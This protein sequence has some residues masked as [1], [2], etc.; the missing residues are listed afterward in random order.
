M[1]F[2]FADEILFELFGT[3]HPIK[4]HNSSL[5]RL[6]VENLYHNLFSDLDLEH[7]DTFYSDFI[8]ERFHTSFKNGLTKYLLGQDYRNRQRRQGQLIR[9]F[10]NREWL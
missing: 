8:F 3:F 6:S 10:Q 9:V 5:V 1:L 2:Y 4:P 7:P